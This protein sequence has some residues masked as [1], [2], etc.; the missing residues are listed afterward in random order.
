MVPEILIG[1]HVLI[2]KLAYNFQNL[3]SWRQ[4]KPGE[5]VAFKAPLYVPHD[6]DSIWIKRVIATEGQRVRIDNGT[7][8]VNNVPYLHLKKNRVVRFMDFMSYGVWQKQEAWATEENTAGYIHPI[9]M[10]NAEEYWPI[11]GQLAL[12]GLICDAVS[13]VVKQ[14]FM[15]VMGDNRGGSTDSRD[16]GAVQ[17]ENIIG[18][19]WLVWMSRDQR[20][21]QFRNRWFKLL[22]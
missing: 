1:D 7:V 18:R 4:P 11:S 16:Y 3:I 13:C 9:Y 6:R 2:F 15:F 12:P 21:S 10:G 20:L 19:P 14:G 5:L 17:V 8:Y 22:S